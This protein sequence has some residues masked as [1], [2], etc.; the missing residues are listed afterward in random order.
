MIRY[1]MEKDCNYSVGTDTVMV[2]RKKKRQF[3]SLFRNVIFTIANWRALELIVDKYN[4]FAN[5]VFHAWMKQIF[6][7][8]PYN[9]DNII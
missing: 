4:R 3:Y 6:A 9:I 5:R 2:E 7:N 8:F 1:R